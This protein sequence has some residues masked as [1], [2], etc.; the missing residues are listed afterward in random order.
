MTAEERGELSAFY[1]VTAG[2]T[3]VAG[4]QAELQA[5]ARQRL[6]QALGAYGFL[7]IVKAKKTFLGHIPAASERLAALCDEDPAWLPLA[8]AT[9]SAAGRFAS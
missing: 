9:R 7:G 1:A 4:W 2:R 3:E 6:M 5:C 8:R